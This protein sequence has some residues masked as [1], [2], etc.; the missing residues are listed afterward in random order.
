MAMQ[1]AIELSND[2]QMAVLP[3]GN[4]LVGWVMK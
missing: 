4:P 2:L 3:A 1:V